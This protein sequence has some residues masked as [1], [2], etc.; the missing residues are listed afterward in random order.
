MIV[1]EL[2][3]LRS[4]LPALALWDWAFERL[5]DLRLAL[6]QSL[7]A[8]LLNVERDQHLVIRNWA[9][10]LHAGVLETGAIDVIVD[11]RMDRACANT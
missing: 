10:P 9:V 7:F 4:G 3:L 5:N 6:V 2:A 8:G 11:G 1:I